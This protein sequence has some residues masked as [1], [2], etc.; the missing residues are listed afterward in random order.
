MDFTDLNEYVSFSKNALDLLK[1]A[2]SFLPKSP[3]RDG[4]EAAIKAAG[5]ALSRSD[6]KLAKELGFR[7]CECTFPGLPMLWKKD[8]GKY[9]KHECPKCG[10]IYPRDHPILDAPS[11]FDSALLGARGGRR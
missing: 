3:Q 4:A 10:D 5:D 7:L 2:T 9:G 6:A 11:K 1:S 8:M